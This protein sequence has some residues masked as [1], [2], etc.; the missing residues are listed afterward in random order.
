MSQA[1]MVGAVIYSIGIAAGTVHV[2]NGAMQEKWRS[3]EAGCD[4]S[5]SLPATRNAQ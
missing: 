1:H 3:T 5:K 2:L 4:P